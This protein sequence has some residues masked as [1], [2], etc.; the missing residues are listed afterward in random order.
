[1]NLLLDYYFNRIISILVLWQGEPL[2]VKGYSDGDILVRD[3][4]EYA[5]YM[6]EGWQPLGHPRRH[7][8]SHRQYRPSR[9]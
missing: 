8:L 4:R 3:N 1:M 7:R 6:D 9:E 2:V 5:I